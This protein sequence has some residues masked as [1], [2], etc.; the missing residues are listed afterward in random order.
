MN[1]FN[2]IKNYFGLA[3]ICDLL[4]WAIVAVGLFFAWS[5]PIS[6][7]LFAIGVIYWLDVVLKTKKRLGT[8]ETPPTEDPEDN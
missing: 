2:F 5:N 6:W 3:V 7:S 4:I 8:L 1:N